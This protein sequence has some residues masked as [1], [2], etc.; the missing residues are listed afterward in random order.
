MNRGCLK[1]MGNNEE[2]NQPYFR[3]KNIMLPSTVSLKEEIWN[4]QG[5]TWQ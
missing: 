4:I 3:R 5:V 1:D 2:E